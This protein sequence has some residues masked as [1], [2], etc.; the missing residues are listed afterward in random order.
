M[1]GVSKAVGVVNAKRLRIHQDNLKYA[2][3]SRSGQGIFSSE[4]RQSYEAQ[5][6]NEFYKKHSSEECAV[7]DEDG[8]LERVSELHEEDCESLEVRE[9]RLDHRANWRVLLDKN[10]VSTNWF[11]GAI[12]TMIVINCVFLALVSSKLHG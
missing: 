8:Q 2:L 4:L 6:E 3:T 11:G 12:L 9:K 7:I 5:L 10:I 1:A